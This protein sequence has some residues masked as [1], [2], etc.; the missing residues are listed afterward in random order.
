MSTQELHIELDILLQ[1]V[2]SSWNKDFLPQEYDLLLNKEITKFIKQRVNP[3][4]N[5]KRQSVFDTLQRVQ[6][7]NSLF[8]TEVIPVTPINQREVKFLLPFDFFGYISSEVTSY[9]DCPEKGV[10]YSNTLSF[11]RSI[12]PIKSLG[13]VLE[14]LQEIVISLTYINKFEAVTT[15]ELFKL[16]SLPEQYLPQDDIQDYLKFFI[17]DNAINKVVKSKLKEINTQARDKIE[18]RFNKETNK[19]EFKCKSQMEIAYLVNNNP[20][21]VITNDTNIPFLYSPTT[22]D[23]PV[24]VIDEEFKSFIKGSNLSNSTE[25]NTK[26]ILREKEMIITMPIGV[27]IRHL[28]LSYICKPIQIDLLLG[29]DSELPDNV[30]T[31]IVS[32][33][34]QSLKG[35]ISSDTYEKFTR[36]NTLIE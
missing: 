3:L 18:F 36:E 30:L 26:A 27:S 5:N 9:Y 34:A 33:T 23:S 12:N 8:R 17:Y 6:N 13:I 15:V 11:N 2:N 16:T 35:I 32:N 28:S 24:S 25:D 7:L 22:F 10:V 1:K 14:E 31:E 29:I 21:V 20:S 4:S 19:F